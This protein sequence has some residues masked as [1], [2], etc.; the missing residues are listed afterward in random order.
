MHFLTIFQFLKIF[1]LETEYKYTIFFR[2]KKPLIGSYKIPIAFTFQV[3]NKSKW[4]AKDVDN[5]K[6]IE[7][8]ERVENALMKSFSISREIV[9][10][11]QI[12]LFSLKYMVIIH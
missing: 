12:L 6:K 11:D 4:Q 1:L 8:S 9:S 10:S 5:S 7:G 2:L 3:N